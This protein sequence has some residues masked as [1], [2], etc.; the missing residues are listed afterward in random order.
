MKRRAFCASAAALL[1][2]AA[3]PLRHSLAAAAVASGGL[4][5][6]RGDGRQIHIA[7]AAIEDLRRRVRGAVLLREDPDYDAARRIW[8]G[9]F[10]RRPA[11]IVR[12]AGAADVPQAVDF[13][14]RAA[15]CSWRYAAAA[16][17]S[18]ASRSARQAR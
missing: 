13:A 18:P 16:T 9:M 17:A 7:R 15:S 4:D 14:R 1:T 3:T 8:N 6:V 2:V 5:A 12:C 10:D 11:V